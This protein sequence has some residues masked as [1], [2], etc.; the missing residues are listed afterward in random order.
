[1]SDKSK[2]R[3]REKKLE[4]KQREEREVAHDRATV[5]GDSLGSGPNSPT[6]L[7]RGGDVLV[8]DERLVGRAHDGPRKS[9]P[10]DEAA[11]QSARQSEDDEVNEP[12]R[13][14]DEP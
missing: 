11:R 7:G 8:E 2:A 4:A 10:P 1:M 3:R 12:R 6:H 9:T 13:D 14:Q 5:S